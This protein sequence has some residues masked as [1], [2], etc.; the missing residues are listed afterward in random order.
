M[1]SQ[2]R[3]TG[4]VVGVVMGVLF[5][6]VVVWAGSL[7]PSVGPTSE[8]SQ[9]Y[10]LEQIYNRLNTG[11]TGAKSTSFTEPSS[12]PASTGHT[13]DEIMGKLPALDDANGAG[14]GNVTQGKTYWG[15]TSG[16]WG[17]KTGT[18]ATP[19]DT[20]L[21]PENI[22]QGVNIFGVVGTY[23]L[24]GVPRIGQSGYGV[25]WPN[26]RFTDNG[27]GTVTDNL[28]GLI[29][30]K[31]ANC[32]G[33]P[34]IANNI[35]L[36]IN[37]MANGSCGLTDGSVAGQWRLPNI[38]EMQSL[39]H[40]DY[41]NPAL[42]NTSGTGKWSAGDPFTNVQSN[43]YWTSSRLAPMMTIIWSVNLGQGDLPLKDPT[44]PTITCYTWP[45][46]GGQ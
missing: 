17:L 40:Y 37:Y 31:N 45:V 36:V 19:V 28:T 43:C 15:L 46:R 8:G 10:T 41:N 34:V 18:M 38:R 23:P 2:N 9:M 22:K 1:R 32:N 12:G 44:Q 11:A 39:V 30:T 14:P 27:N 25:A 3:W 29:W 5:S 24:A 4:R 16:Q 6:A 35:Y 21:V 33:I 13:L 42:P 7:D 26:P 20:D